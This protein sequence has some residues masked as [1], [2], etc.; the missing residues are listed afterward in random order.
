MCSRN[1]RQV[2][3]RYIFRT[4]DV[5]EDAHLDADELAHLASRPA[6]APRGP[7]QRARGAVPQAPPARARR[8][9]LAGG[10]RG[11]GRRAAGR[12]GRPHGARPIPS[13]GRWGHSRARLRARCLLCSGEPP[14]DR[15]G[16][17]PHKGYGAVISTAEWL[18]PRHG[19]D[20]AIAMGGAAISTPPC[21][22]R[23]ENPPRR[24]IAENHHKLCSACPR[25]AHP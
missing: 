21:L 2:R 1:V 3:A 11:R 18:V 25:R 8:G 7:R 4:Y 23:T 5:N 17:S 9:R 13:A 6:H 10:G 16:D 22:L 14:P 12:A 15:C 19:S 24:H 20:H